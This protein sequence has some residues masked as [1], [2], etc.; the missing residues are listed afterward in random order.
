M[1]VSPVLN[2]GWFVFVKT[3]SNATEFKFCLNCNWD[4]FWTEFTLN[5]FLPIFSWCKT[6]SWSPW[7][8]FMMCSADYVSILTACMVQWGWRQHRVG[9]RIC[10]KKIGASLLWCVCV[11]Q[12]HAVLLQYFYK[13]DDKTK[14]TPSLRRHYS[15]RYGMILTKIWLKQNFLYLLCF[16]E[17]SVS[18]SGGGTSRPRTSTYSKNARI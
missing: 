14:C 4:L 3:E 8:V 11:T 17:L 7:M 13:N 1:F 9:F 12:N 18:Q 10:Q 16:W 15:C 6:M 2:S 5:K